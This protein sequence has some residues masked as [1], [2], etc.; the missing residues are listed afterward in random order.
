MNKLNELIR[1][2]SGQEN[3]FIQMHNSPDPDAIGSAFGLQYLL[4]EKGIKAL[5]CY[6]GEIDKYNTQKMI[7]LLGIKVINVSEINNMN[8]HDYIILIDSQKGNS[9]VADFIGNEVAA[10]DHHPVFQKVDYIFEDIRPEIGACS[11]IVAKYFIDNN[12][13]IPQKVA[14]ALLY[15]IKMDTLD[16][17]RGVSH[18]DLDMFCVLYKQSDIDLINKIQANT[19][20]FEELI[21]YGNAIKNIKVYGNVG[22]ANVAVDCPDSLLGTV[23]DFIISIKEVEF[24]VVY[25]PR[26]SGLKFSVRNEI[27]DLDAGKAVYTAL[28]DIGN[29]GGHKSMAG[30]F[31]PSCNLSK[32][33][34]IDSFVEDRFLEIINHKNWID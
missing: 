27:E 34:E 6:K 17:T 7:D 18:E 16:L 10:I 20:Q 2:I 5:I 14:T 21:A 13:S 31:L 30:G 26:Q 32:I 9:N 33:G 11:T 23:A 4:N 15:G 12:I 19:L 1:V 8:V 25:S 22:F 29:G 28:R 24:A 3:I